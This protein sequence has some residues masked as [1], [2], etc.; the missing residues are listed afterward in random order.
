MTANADSS[1]GMELLH[2]ISELYVTVRG[3]A[4][5]SFC[6]E[7]YKQCSKIQFENLNFYARK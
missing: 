7:L 4:F 3:F 2:Q 6:L 5:A 1:I